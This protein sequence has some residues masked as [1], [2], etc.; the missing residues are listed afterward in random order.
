MKKGETFEIDPDPLSLLFYGQLPENLQRLYCGLE[1]IRGGIHGVSKVS[2][3]YHIHPHTVRLGK[4]ELLSGN[5]LPKGQIRRSGGGRKKKAHLMDQLP[6]VIMSILQPYT[7]GSP[8]NESIKWTNLTLT[9]ISELLKGNGLNVGRYV[10]KG[11]M[12]Q[13]GYV[14]RKMV[15]CETVTTVEFRNEQFEN[16]KKFTKEFTSGGLPVLSID[17]K[18]KEMLGKFY[19]EGHLLTHEY[20]KVFDHDFKSFSEGTVVPHGIY[21]TF[22]NTCYLT[23]GQSADTAE[24]MC[25]NL[26]YHWE[27]HIRAHYPEAKKMLLLCDGGGS[28]SSRSHLVKEALCHLFQKIEMEIVVAHYPPY[29][30][31]WNP[32]EHK[33]F[34]HITRAWQ[35]IVFDSMQ[36]VEDKAK[37]ATTKTGFSV[38]VWRNKEEYKTGQKVSKDWDEKKSVKFN[39]LLP[40][41]NY[42]FNAA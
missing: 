13:L 28:N 27:N 39:T 5:L 8:M 35:G 15:K 9:R 41:W 37:L 31:K 21:D 22:H 33:A 36:T 24:F 10:V 14:R 40:K 25:D 32:V 38:E 4:Q 19:R 12:K 34:C 18:K 20:I 11:L 29:C 42:V 30:S 17:T 26:Y 7:A 6:S 23:L 16:I 1:A 2:E 3:F